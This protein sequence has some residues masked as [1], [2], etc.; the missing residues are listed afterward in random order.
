MRGL[1]F[2]ILIA[3]LSSIAVAGN[4]QNSVTGLRPLDWHRLYA[5]GDGGLQ[6]GT[7]TIIQANPQVGY[8]ITDALS[9]GFAINYSY[10]HWAE[11][12][13]TTTAYG[14]ELFSRLFVFQ[15][16]YAI[17]TYGFNSF[18]ALL[19][20]NS[21]SY[22]FRRIHIPYGMAG[23]GLR[24]PFSDLG[25]FLIEGL[26]DFRYGPYSISASPFVIRGGI[27]FGF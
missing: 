12:Q 2:W 26:Y 18:V 16:F 7:I 19:P 6:L 15:N 17:G 5:G 27:V 10:Y 14:G 25:A 22:D 9:A 1:T 24:E 8:K 13:Y 20:V 11:Y 23:L 3:L 4:A 21:T